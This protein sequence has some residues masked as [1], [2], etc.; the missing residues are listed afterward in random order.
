M[1]EPDTAALARRI[2]DKAYL[3]G[4]F[5]LRS[6]QV[7]NDYFDKY[8][9]EADPSLLRDICEVMAPMV[10]PG[11]DALAGLE[12]GGIPVV[13][14]LSQLTGLPAVFVRKTAK[15]YGTCQFAEGLDV[16]G[17]HL[18]VI[19]DVVTSGGQVVI[20]TGMLRDAGATITSAL[21][22]IDREAGGREALGAAGIKLDAVLTRTELES[23]VA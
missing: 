10:P 5:T 4:E 1:A 9:F 12:M 7:S 21:C 20:S 17:K 23:A 19:E 3:T 14:V 16:E 15:V 2:W 8:R 22:V 6:G 18:L 11:I 13:T